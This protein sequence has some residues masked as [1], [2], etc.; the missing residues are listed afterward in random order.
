M[1]QFS[2]Q[3]NNDNQ[4]YQRRIQWLRNSVQLIFLAILVGGLYKF[5]RPAFVVILPLAFLAGNFFC[6]WLCPFGTAQEVLG[7]IGSIFMRKKFKVSPNIQRYLQFSRYILA[8]IVFAHIADSLFNLSSINAYKTFMRAMSGN[9]AQT[10]ATF[11]MISFLAVA[12]FFER[13]FCNYFCPEGIKFGLASLTRF[14]SIKRNAETCI[15]CKC[16]DRACPM[17]IE[18]SKG[19]HVRNAQCINCF[20]CIAAC[21]KRG[22]LTYGGV[23]PLKRE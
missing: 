16:C 6:S 13:P 20:K 9:L 10:T 18:V 23:N 1:Q 4:K 3:N 2:I 21:P 8:A 12:L 19:N 22:T 17:N 15:H 5:I 14:L 7:K 11:I